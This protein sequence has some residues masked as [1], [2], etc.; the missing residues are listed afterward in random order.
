MLVYCTY[1]SSACI[2]SAKLAQRA[3]VWGDTYPFVYV[4]SR[5]LHCT[6]GNWKQ[7]RIA[8]QVQA[9]VQAELDAVVGRHTLVNLSHRPSL[10]YTD[11][12]LTEITRLG[13]VGPLASTRCPNVDVQIGGYTIRKGESALKHIKL[14]E[15]M[16][17]MCF[18][19]S[20]TV[21][22]PLLYG[23]TRD[24]ER[25]EDPEEFRPERHL[26]EEGKLRN[27]ETFFNFGTGIHNYSESSMQK[28]FE[29]RPRSVSPF[30]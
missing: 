20:D 27:E 21:V 29:T 28:P 18:V 19:L 14:W 9:R 25:F 17:I 8:F 23:V 12:V 22:F 7:N 5:H 2:F 4:T 15:K 26:T 1:F 30:S 13:Q 24:P 11:A 6:I 16:T 10:S 3:Q